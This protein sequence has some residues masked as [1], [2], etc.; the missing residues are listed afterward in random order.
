M[1][2]HHTTPY[3]TSKAKVGQYWE[4]PMMC[5]LWVCNHCAD[6]HL[7]VFWEI[8]VKGYHGTRYQGTRVFLKFWYQVTGYTLK[9]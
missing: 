7:F 9:F 6:D 2:P 1:I 4:I 3:H 8:S 5:L